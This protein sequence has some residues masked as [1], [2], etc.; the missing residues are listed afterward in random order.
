MRRFS[1]VASG[2]LFG[3]IG[4]VSPS[5]T[6]SSCRA[7]TPRFSSSKRHEHDA[8]LGELQV[9][10][11]ARQLEGVRLDHDAVASALLADG[12]R[13]L[14]E[15]DVEARLERS[16]RRIPEWPAQARLADAAAYLGR[17]GP[18]R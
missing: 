11:R 18:G 8:E 2:S 4:R 7:G 12:A 17:L 1:N 16:V 13:D 9:Q 6:G 3:A 14:V 5:A 10:R 15:R